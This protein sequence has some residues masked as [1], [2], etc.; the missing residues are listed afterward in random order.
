MNRDTN[1]AVTSGSY[2]RSAATLE[3]EITS[4]T[5]AK[6]LKSGNRGM[7]GFPDPAS[8]HFSGRKSRNMSSFCTSGTAAPLCDP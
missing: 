3:T 2:S 5:S 8:T 7:V 6:V 4:T 1:L